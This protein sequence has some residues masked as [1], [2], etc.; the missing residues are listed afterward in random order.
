MYKWVYIVLEGYSM[1][2]PKKVTEDLFNRINNMDLEECRRM[3]ENMPQET[4]GID[5][6]ILKMIQKRIASLK[7]DEA[8]DCK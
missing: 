1:T 2:I 4:K 7:Q 5:K 6:T 8:V 3:A